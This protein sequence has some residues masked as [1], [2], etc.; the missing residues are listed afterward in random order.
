MSAE[1]LAPVVLF[2]PTSAPNRV[3]D[4]RLTAVAALKD[5]WEDGEGVAFTPD[6]LLRVQCLL[7]ATDP[8]FSEGVILEPRVDG[9]VLLMFYLFE[10]LPPY[11]EIKVH[12]R[13]HYDVFTAADTDDEPGDSEVDTTMYD[14]NEVIAALNAWAKRNLHGGPLVAPVVEAEGEERWDFP[15]PLLASPGRT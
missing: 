9:E 2:T 8:T 14:L 6:V 4:T 7:S 5:G 15:D 12:P 13:G 3:P 11:V 1:V 10:G